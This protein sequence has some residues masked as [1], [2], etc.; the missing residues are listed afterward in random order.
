M[1]RGGVPRT[2][3]RGRSVFYTYSYTFTI[4]DN[5]KSDAVELW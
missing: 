1:L 5:V 4:L 2:C 3:R